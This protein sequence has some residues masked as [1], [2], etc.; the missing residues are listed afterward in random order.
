[1]ERKNTKKF[2]FVFMLGNQIIRQESLE[3]TL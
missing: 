1:M 2:G 3:K